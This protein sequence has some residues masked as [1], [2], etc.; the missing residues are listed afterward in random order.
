MIQ[1]I[2]QDPL[3]LH[4]VELRD[5]DLCD[6]HPAASTYFRPKLFLDVAACQIDG[7][8][9]FV[10]LSDREMRLVRAQEHDAQS[11]P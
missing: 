6:H 2:R 9:F 7:V 1:A 4:L 10:A 5:W 11:L 3:V 8:A